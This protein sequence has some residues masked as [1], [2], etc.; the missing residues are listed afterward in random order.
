MFERLSRGTL[1][2]I[3]SLNTP[4]QIQ[5]YIDTEIAYDP[6]REDRSVVQVIDERKAECYN[7]ALLAA[8]C[9]LYHGYEASITELLAKDDEEHVICVYKVDNCFGSIAQSKFLGLKSRSPMYISI[10][11]LAVSYKEFYFAFE[12]GRYSLVS[13]TDWFPIEKYENAW[14]TDSQCVIKMEKD[15]Q[16]APHYPLVGETAKP[17]YVSPERF[18]SEVRIVPEGTVIS[19]KFLKLKP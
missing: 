9:L 19:D 2:L 3:K 12:D 11:D 5:K 10:R 13:Y 4:E 18:W 7:G 6:Y 16:K 17:Y 8:A 15:L 14:F 1:E